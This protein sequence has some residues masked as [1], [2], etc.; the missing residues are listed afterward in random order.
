MSKEKRQ[1]LGTPRFRMSL[2]KYTLHHQVKTGH[3]GGCGRR[4]VNLKRS[5]GKT[6]QLHIKFYKEQK[7]SSLSIREFC[8]ELMQMA[9]GR[10]QD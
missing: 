10:R 6:S 2:P 9:C 5:L 7:A 3:A 1:G 8:E 4:E